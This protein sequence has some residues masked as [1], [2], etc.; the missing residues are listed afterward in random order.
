MGTGEWKGP[1]PEAANRTGADSRGRGTLVAL[2]RLADYSPLLA[3]KSGRQAVILGMGPNKK[4]VGWWIG[5]QEVKEFETSD[6][7]WRFVT[8]LKTWS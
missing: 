3:E 5:S 8:R 2:Y 4:M 6:N 1:P 7:S